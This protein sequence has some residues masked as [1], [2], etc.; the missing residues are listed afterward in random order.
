M[1]SCGLCRD[2][3]RTDTKRKN[4]PSSPKV[5][6]TQILP[7]NLKKKKSCISTFPKQTH[8]LHYA[9]TCQAFNH[10]LLNE[11][12]LF[13]SATEFE[14]KLSSRLNTLDLIAAGMRYIGK[15]PGKNC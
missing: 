3:G 12:R 11:F 2:P 1:H 9:K 7:I 15:N 10:L 14:N 13:H 5:C 4:L 6:E 8:R